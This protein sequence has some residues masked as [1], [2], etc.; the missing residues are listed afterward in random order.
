MLTHPALVLAGLM[1]SDEDWR[2]IDIPVADGRKMVAYCPVPGSA[3]PAS[4]FDPAAAALPSPAGGDQLSALEPWM[5]M[6][7]PHE[8]R[9]PNLAPA[10]EPEPEPVS[11]TEIL[12]TEEPAPETAVDPE[13]TGPMELFCHAE[14][15]RWLATAPGLTAEQLAAVQ[16]EMEADEYI[17]EDLIGMTA[18]NLQRLV[19]G[20]AAEACISALLSARDDYVAAAKAAV[21]P[22]HE[23]LCPISQDLMKDPVVCSNGQCYERVEIAKWLKKHQRDPLS[24]AR[25]KDKKLTP[26]VPLK[27]L[28]RQWQEEHPEYDGA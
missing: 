9:I 27:K 16:A 11:E 3:S 18:R 26:N 8:P 4:G 20:T 12:D 28:I 21:K 10:P 25:L 6:A 23:Y 7:P 24:N 15:L 22:P 17:G 1:S 2:E 19:R 13:L 5:A 14:V